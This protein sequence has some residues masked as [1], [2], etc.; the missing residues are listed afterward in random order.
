MKSVSV[1]SSSVHV[2]VLHWCGGFLV[3][4]CPGLI[5]W[6]PGIS[7][8]TAAGYALESLRSI[9]GMFIFVDVC[10]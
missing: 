10:V 2:G 7:V 1:P 4:L 9:G 6:S 8:G 3:F 5:Y